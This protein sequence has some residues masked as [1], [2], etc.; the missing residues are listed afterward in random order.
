M[1]SYFVHFL[2]LFPLAHTR[3]LILLVLMYSWGFF[4]AMTRTVL[5]KTLPVFMAAESSAVRMAHD[6]HIHGH[7]AIF[8]LGYFKKAAMKYLNSLWCSWVYSWESNHWWSVFHVWL[9]GQQQTDSKG[10]AVVHFPTSMRAH[11]PLS[12]YPHTLDFFQFLFFTYLVCVKWI[13]L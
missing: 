13:S 9:P 10:S 7:V 3:V 8:T 4:M 6:C 2:R 1:E 11:L 5:G 12:T